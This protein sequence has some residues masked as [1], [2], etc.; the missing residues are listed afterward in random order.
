MR[1]G[2]MDA[3]SVEEVVAVDSEVLQIEIP[4]S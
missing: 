3:T 4:H 1:K 2:L